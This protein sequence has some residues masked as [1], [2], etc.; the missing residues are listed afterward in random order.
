MVRPRWCYGRKAFAP[1]P[2]RQRLPSYTH[3]SCT[4]WGVFIWETVA[5][6][7]EAREGGRRLAKRALVG[8]K[9]L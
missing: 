2:H 7:A 9:V 4:D 6:E 1:A 5:L 3:R 8:R